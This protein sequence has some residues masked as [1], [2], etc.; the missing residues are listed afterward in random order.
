MRYPL[1]CSAAMLVAREGLVPDRSPKNGETYNPR[2]LRVRP[3]KMLVGSD[4]PF[5]FGFRWFFRGK[6]AVILRGGNTI[7]SGWR[8]PLHPRF[9][10]LEP[11]EMYVEVEPFGK[12][13]WDLTESISHMSQ[14]QMYECTYMYID[15]KQYIHKVSTSGSL[16]VYSSRNPFWKELAREICQK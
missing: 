5:L 2:K 3:W 13:D 7:E 15:K 9:H 16:V 11:P 8:W 6:L 10:Q 4:D 1:G 14:N 12:P